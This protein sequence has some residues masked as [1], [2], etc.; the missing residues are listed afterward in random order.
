MW[1]YAILLLVINPSM[2]EDIDNRLTYVRQHYGVNFE[3]V[4]KIITDGGSTVYSHTWLIPWPKFSFVNLP[5]MTCKKEEVIKWRKR[6]LVIKQLIRNSNIDRYNKYTHLI[7]LLSRVT[8]LVPL[9]DDNYIKSRLKRDIDTQD[10]NST[11]P[12]WLEESK[13]D[14]ATKFITDALPSYAVGRFFSSLTGTP[15]KKD[16][17]QVK[18]KLRYVGSAIYTNREG[19]LQFERDISSLSQ[20]INKRVDDLRDSSNTIFT[21]LKDT[22]YE[23][24]ETYNRIQLEEKG[25]K[26][27]L[28]LVTEINNQFIREILPILLES[29]LMMMNISEYVHDWVEGINILT[30]GYL[31][32]QIIPEK[33]VIDLLQHIISLITNNAQ[34]RTLKLLSRDPAYIY[35]L[36]NVIYSKILVPSL[37][38]SQKQLYL[39]VNIKVPLVRTQ[40]LLP[41]YR[42]DT[43]PVPTHSGLIKTSSTKNKGVTYIHNLADYIAISENLEIY[44][45]MDKNTY[46]SCTGKQG[47]KYCNLGTSSIKYTRTKSSRPCEYLLFSDEQDEIAKNCQ[48]GYS[49]LK[50]ISLVGSAVQIKSDS[51]YLMHASYGS[52]MHYNEKW[53]LSCPYSKKNPTRNIRVCEMCRLKIPCQCSLS[54]K[55]FFLPQSFTNCVSQSFHTV[56]Y[57]NTVNLPFVTQLFTQKNLEQSNLY[58]ELQNKFFSRIKIPQIN[59]TI[60]D[61]FSLALALSDKYNADLNKMFTNIKKKMPIFKNKVDYALNKTR[62][63]SDAIAFKEANLMTGI[64]QLFKGILGSKLGTILGVIFS[65]FG[66]LMIAFILSAFEFIPSFALDV[67]SYIL[68]HRKQQN[69]FLMAEM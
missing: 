4:D 61:N 22:I 2:S 64:H 6:C 59:F 7:K 24:N 19:I 14:K 48:I 28:A 31:P 15:N 56:N 62:D 5:K 52:D 23:M 43:Y 21:R 35:S 45:L 36:Q 69:S 41:L 10:L 51:S 66:F 58:Q 11:I 67:H 3:L 54:A 29:N 27:R 9:N 18:A 1:L 13:S 40:G 60:P 8:S 20:V 38:T 44:L 63:M 49:K 42:I 17:Y 16:V 53:K 12:K 32:P 25:L 55:N 47:L 68:Q 46:F 30:T 50:D 65:P 37:N 26:F 39:V 33:S 57:I 34:Y